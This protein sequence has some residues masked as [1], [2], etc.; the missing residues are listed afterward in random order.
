MAQSGSLY[1]QTIFTGGIVQPSQKT[2]VN[3]RSAA[4]SSTVQ[5]TAIGT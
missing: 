2:D 1:T 4:D 5:M 3:Q